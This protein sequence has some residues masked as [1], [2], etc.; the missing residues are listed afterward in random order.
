M[1]TTPHTR[2]F[3]SSAALLTA[4][5]LALAA[6][7]SAPV[8]TEQLAVTT[9]AVAQ[10]VSVGGQELAPAEMSAARDKLVRAQLAVAAKEDRKSTRLN[11]SHSTL[12]RMPSSA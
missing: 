6:C 3:N 12:S 1:N 4:S 7:A 11:S 10:A 8:P 2:R 5:V 9:A